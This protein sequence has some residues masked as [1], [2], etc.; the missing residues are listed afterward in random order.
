MSV[1]ERI[2]E[3]RK[4]RNLSQAELARI[5]DV[6]RQAVSKWENGQSS[7]DTVKLIHLA[8]VLDTEVEFLC[9]YFLCTRGP[10]WSSRTCAHFLAAGG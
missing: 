5:M 1:G 9:G 8:D 3:L 4:K 10:S 7:P 2:A 6:S